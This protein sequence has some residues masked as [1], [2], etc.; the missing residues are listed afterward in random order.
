MWGGQPCSQHVPGRAAAAGR[1]GESRRAGGWNRCLLEFSEGAGKGA[2]KGAGLR[3]DGALC[4]TEREQA[5][6][7]TCRAA[8]ETTPGTPAAALGQLSQEKEGAQAFRRTDNIIYFLLP[9]KL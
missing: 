7:G 5:W 4:H 8:P 9:Q 6:P 2:G 3:G 1:D